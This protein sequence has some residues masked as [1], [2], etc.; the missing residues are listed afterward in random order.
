MT[1]YGHGTRASLLFHRALER[2]LVFAG[3]VHHLCHVSSAGAHGLIDVR[4][5]GVNLKTFAHSEIYRF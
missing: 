1:N 2:V 5:P 4:D 3:K